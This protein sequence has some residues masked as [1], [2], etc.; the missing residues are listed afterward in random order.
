MAYKGGMK[1]ELCI[2]AFEAVYLQQQ[3]AALS[4]FDILAFSWRVS[5]AS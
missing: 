1:V 3:E 4:I 2:Y 5:I